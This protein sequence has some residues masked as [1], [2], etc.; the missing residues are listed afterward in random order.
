MR[1][2]VTALRALLFAGLAVSLLLPG[3]ALSLESTATARGVAPIAVASTG[4][5]VPA[6]RN[7]I[8][9]PGA[10]AGDTSAGGWDAVT[11]PGWSVRSGLPT[12]VKYGT[13]GFPSAKDPGPRAKGQKLFAGGA[14]GT[15]VLSQEVRLQVAGGGALKAGTECRLSAWLAGWQASYATA[16]AAL[17]SSS[18]RTLGTIRLAKVVAAPRQTKPGG[19]KLESASA[20]L[21]AKTWGVK[22][23]LTLGTILKNYDGPDSPIVGYNRSAAD[24]VSLTVNAPTA[25]PPPLR[26][27]PSKAPRFKHVFLI[28]MENEDLKAIVGDKSQAPFENSLL[29]QGSLLTNFY[30]EEHPS[31]GNYLAIAGG[32][33]FGIPLTDPLEENPL[34]TIKARNLGDLVDSAHE[35]WRAYLQSANGPCDDT[36]HGYYW[37]DDLPFLYFEDVRTHPAYCAEHVSPLYQLTTDLAKAS[38]TPSFSWVGADDC[39]D[40]EG[41]GI[42]AGDNFLRSVVADITRSEAWRTQSSLIAITFDEDGYDYERPA[43]L[44]PT[45]VLGSHVRKDYVS[46]FRYTHYSLLRTIEAAL[47]LGTL[48]DNDRYAAPIN[49]IFDTGASSAAPSLKDATNSDPGVSL[50]SDLMIAPESQPVPEISDGRSPTAFIVNSASN[51]VT[52]VDIAS[53]RAE[54]PIKVG[55]HPTA[56]A[57]APDGRF[58]Y[59][60]NNGSGSVTPVNIS[61]FRPLSPIRVGKDPDA[62][63]IGDGGATAYVANEGSGSVSAISLA[64]ATVVRVI[65]VGLVPVALALTP[66][67]NTLYVADE[68]SSVVTPIDT[69]T[70]VA[71]APIRVG[72][73]PFAMAITPSGRTL[74]V[75]NFGSDTVTPVDVLTN[76][77]MPSIRVGQAPDAIAIANGG[78]IAYVVNGDSQ[79][80]TPIGIAT[81]KT[82]PHILVGYSPTGIAASPSGNLV[83]V[84]NSISGTVT[85]IESPTDKRL[86]SISVGLYN[87]PTVVAFAAKS[88]FAEVICPYGGVVATINATSL[89]RVAITS[90]GNYPSAIGFAAPS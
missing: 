62:I 50:P 25:A 71:G 38:T 44:V 16:E 35:S 33:A 47:G 17:V 82:L 11:I 56:V 59:V 5:A 68:G 24:N 27:P 74:Y 60:V 61:T 14:G 79:S 75:V 48:T 66:N 73:A 18:G 77:A 51:S 20:R 22:V 30:A 28:M 83:L 32:G 52:P 36:V 46:H 72:D 88:A 29:R 6:G 65:P 2:L 9:N 55:L 13:S 4:H 23:V 8:L 43:Q 39:Y 49:D 85:P 76:A 34:F 42:R 86:P 45:I 54:K 57:I 63:V 19:L 90:V 40:M 87:Y 26:P 3:S 53:H 41:C 10:E 89:K 58:A 67:G 15:A 21:P 31:D 1:R 12:V 64:K 37:N 7:L 70:N 81:N 84:T 69:K 78:K 80:V